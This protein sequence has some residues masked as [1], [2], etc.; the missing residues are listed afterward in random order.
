[1]NFYQGTKKLCG[2]RRNEFRNNLTVIIVLKMY[3]LKKKMYTIRQE[4]TGSNCFYKSHVK[5]D[6]ISFK[7]GRQEL[8][9]YI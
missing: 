1:M 9:V 6:C 2:D 4:K 8:Y 5:F 7:F 3:L